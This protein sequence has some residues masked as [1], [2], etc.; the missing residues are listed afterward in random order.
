MTACFQ[1][2]PASWLFVCLTILIHTTH[3]VPLCHSISLPRKEN[4]RD[5]SETDYFLIPVERFTTGTG[6][7]CL[8]HIISPLWSKLKIPCLLQLLRFPEVFPVDL[9]KVRLM[10]LLSE[11]A[12]EKSRGN[13]FHN[14]I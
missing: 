13:H 7:W 1:V 10:F 8:N 5:V 12:L 2:P 6:G 9:N 4:P 14:V 11:E 3:I